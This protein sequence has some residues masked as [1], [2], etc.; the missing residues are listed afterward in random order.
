[1]S[2]RAATRELI[3]RVEDSSGRPV[4][5]QTDPSLKVL[6]TMR[7]ARG[8]A[9][10]HLVAYNPSGGI[11]PD[12]LI[13]F[14]CGFILRLFANPPS[15]RY[16]FAGSTTGRA[17]TLEAVSAQPEIK[18][19]SLPASAVRA[20]ADHIF[21]GLMTQ[22]RSAPIGLRVDSW[23]AADYPELR[24]LQQTFALRQLQDNQQILSPE[25][26]RLAVSPTYEA[27][28]AMNAAFAGY[29]ARVLD[30]PS[31][32]LPY[33]A[34]GVHLGQDLLASWDAIDAHPLYDRGLIESWA[35]KLKLQGWYEWVP[36]SLDA[37]AES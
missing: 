17:R 8:A 10:A 34:T 37:G 32:V 15:E 31:F 22:L 2:L 6:A 4:L 3:K 30:Q 23:L 14:Q 27:S 16:D 36:Y 18:K 1:M 28:A 24:E 11:A 25:V 7:M 20:Y 19:L 26:Q 13:S 9:P 12:Y 29:W 35:H 5:V 21:D 33:K